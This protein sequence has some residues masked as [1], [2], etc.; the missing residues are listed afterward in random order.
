[1]AFN[2]LPLE[3]SFVVALNNR[4]QEVIER[5][6]LRRPSP[7]TR[8]NKLQLCNNLVEV[9][10]RESDVFLHCHLLEHFVTIRSK[11]NTWATENNVDE[12]AAWT[13]CINAGI[14]R[15][16][17]WFEASLSGLVDLDAHI[18]PLD[19][20]LVWHT[21]LQDPVE[22]KVFV[23][24]TGL[25]FSQWNPDALSRAL[26]IDESG[27]FRPSWD[28]MR[29]INQVHYQEDVRTFMDMSI[30]CVFT[31]EDNNAIT[32]AV[33]RL[34]DNKRMSHKIATSNGEWNFTCN[35]H[36][37]AQHQ[38][39]LAERVLKFSWHRI[40]SGCSGV[41]YLDID[42]V[43]RTHILAPGE[44]RRFCIET[45]GGLVLNIPSPPG[46]H[47]PDIRFLDDTSRVYE[48]VFGEEYAV[49]LC[50][51][52][53]DGRRADDPGSW[54]LKWF[55]SQVSRTQASDEMDRRRYAA[56][57][58]SF[59]FRSKQCNKCGS[60]SWRHCR[61]EDIVE[62]TEREPLLHGRSTPDRVPTPAASVSA[63]PSSRGRSEPTTVPFT[64]LE[65]SP[66]RSE[67]I[68]Q[69]P[70]RSSSSSTHLETSGPT[71][72]YTGGETAIEFHDNNQSR[73]PTP[74]LTDRFTC[75]S[76][77]S[78][79]EGHD[80]RALEGCPNS[81]QTPLLEPTFTSRTNNRNAG[82]TR[83]GPRGRSRVS[84]MAGPEPGVSLTGQVWY[85]G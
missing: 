55:P 25:E 3:H 33:T 7:F 74:G 46:I 2:C 47:E 32:Q 41:T 34:F 80:S 58:I 10:V 16:M 43:W 39:D 4:I 73:P 66:V 77:D 60:H 65:I 8:L 84:R 76:Y 78:D 18:P 81:D 21:F 12:S 22:W 56:M 13:C 1:M 54:T 6:L 67:T 38:L 29:K 35:F 37:A 85:C 53:V 72:W 71:L 19:V 64:D 51:P 11:I 42:L 31:Q 24:R 68:C 79:E 49:C 57:D 50:W 36:L 28:C 44:Y 45:Y 59:T 82:A 27:E 15:L 40:T 30:D 48:H 23:D 62:H 63:L 70:P 17:Q 14:R 61:K 9:S 26:R 52:C 69:I 5:S 75:T 83:D 20:L